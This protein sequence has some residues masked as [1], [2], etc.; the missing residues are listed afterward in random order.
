MSSVASSKPKWRQPQLDY[1]VKLTQDIWLDG[2]RLAF[3]NTVHKVKQYIEM[4]ARQTQMPPLRIM[5][6]ITGQLIGLYKHE[7]EYCTE[8]GEPKDGQAA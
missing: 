5:S 2:K 3:A 7:F 4:D 1:W 8:K 6:P